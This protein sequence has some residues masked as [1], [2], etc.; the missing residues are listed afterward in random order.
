VRKTTTN[1]SEAPRTVSARKTHRRSPTPISVALITRVTLELGRTETGVYVH[2][3]FE[4]AI[5]AFE[6]DVRRVA[7]LLQGCQSQLK[8]DE[9]R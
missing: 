6:Q 7:E 1:Q 3:H 9:S 5:A 8:E 4:T 2:T